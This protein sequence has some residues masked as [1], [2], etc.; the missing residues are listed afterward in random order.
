[1]SEDDVSALEK[2]AAQKKGWRVRVRNRL[3]GWSGRVSLECDLEQILDRGEGR[4]LLAEGTGRAKALRWKQAWFM[5]EQPEGQG[6][7]NGDNG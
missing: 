4:V 6:V 2:N 5:K 7:W 3:I 1:M